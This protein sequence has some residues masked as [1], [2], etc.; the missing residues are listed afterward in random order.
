MNRLTMAAL[1]LAGACGGAQAGGQANASMEVSFVI[2]AACT[3]QAVQPDAAPQVACSQGVGYQVARQPAQDR[4]QAT[5]APGAPLE[6]ART[7][8]T[9][10][11]IF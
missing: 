2:R 8:D 7:G 5:Q 1:L 10:H 4:Q 11:I 6:A 3:V 9:W